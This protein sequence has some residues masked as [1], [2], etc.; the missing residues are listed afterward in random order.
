M[1]AVLSIHHSPESA[2]EPLCYPVQ[3]ESTSMLFAPVTPGVDTFH[4]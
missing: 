3:R 2:E 1:I 4:Y